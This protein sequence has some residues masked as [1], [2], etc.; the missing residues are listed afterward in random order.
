MIG[1]AKR[2]ITS[3]LVGA[4]LLGCMGVS[5]K[6]SPQELSETTKEEYYAEYT[7]I[8]AE[9]ADKT[10]RDISVLPM[11]QFTEEDWVTPEE[12]RSL[13][14]AFADWRIVCTEAQSRSKASATKLSALTLDDR[15]YTV[16]ITGDFDTTN[17]SNRLYF[18]GIRSI[19]SGMQG[20]IWEQTGYE[21]RCIDASRTYAVYVSGQ[22]TVAGA[23]FENVLAYTEFYCSAAGDV[24]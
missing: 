23:V 24:A 14:T 12:F 16:A 11:Y 2:A 17:S 1:K 19:T 9:I 15:E 10:D 22:F 18:S 20:A 6:A 13:L 5:A 7:E 21:C 3:F 8:A 4:M